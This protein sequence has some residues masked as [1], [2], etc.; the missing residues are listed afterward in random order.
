[1][2]PVLL[3]AP[4]RPLA[5]ALAAIGVAVTVTLAGRYAGQSRA[6][7]LDTA[8][9]VRLETRLGGYP[10]LRVVEHLGD[11]LTV[12]ILTGVL[13]LL[14]LRR[15]GWR[16]ALLMVLAIPAAGVI[17][18]F[19]LKPLVRR[20]MDGGLAYPSGHAT[21]VFAIAMVLAVLLVAPPAPRP[22][23]A[24][25]VLLGC[26]GFAVAGTVCVAM[27]A[28]RVHYA[29]DTIGGAAV[30]TAVVLLTALVLD[31]LP[32]RP[33]TPGPPAPAGAPPGQPPVSTT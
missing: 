5:A 11:A 29:T 18:Q 17:T 4:L 25:R 28:N 23:A 3:P 26:A 14:F 1:M 27:V 19:I 20:T 16:A 31:L 21:G 22:P 9:G 30:A 7:W 32:D 2:G 33:R 13:G 24:V 6:G 15:R 10:W 12:I 8:I